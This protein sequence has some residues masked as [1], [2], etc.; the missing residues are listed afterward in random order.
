M[1]QFLASLHYCSTYYL[2][3]EFANQQRI[4]KRHYTLRATYFI[5]FSL[6]W[7]YLALLFEGI[8]TLQL[9]LEVLPTS[10]KRYHLDIKISETK[11]TIFTHQYV[12]EEYPET[13][14]SIN[15]TPRENTTIFKYL[16]YSIKYNELSITYSELE[17]RIV[18]EK[19]KFHEL[20][21]NMM[22]FKKS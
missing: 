22:D 9:A 16:A 3:I 6:C 10:F 8:K 18:T 14:V 12:N 15:N 21:K 1:D 5:F 4:W 11:T 7:P 13:I 2:N 20:G 17:M 19:Y